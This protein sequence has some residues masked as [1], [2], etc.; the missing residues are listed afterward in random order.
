MFTL[1]WGGNDFAP[2]LLVEDSIPI[3]DYLQ[4]H[5]INSLIK[6]A[7]KL[8]GLPNVIGF[9]VMNEP[10]SGYIGVEDL[11]QKISFTY[12]GNAPTPAQSI[13]LGSGIPTEVET[14]SLGSFGI[15]QGENVLLNIAGQSAWLSG[16]KGIWHRQ[17]VWEIVDDSAIILQPNYFSQIDG[18]LVDFT[19]D[20]FK[21]FV[22]D[23]ANAIHEVDSTWLIFIEPS[24][25]PYYSPLPD[26]SSDDYHFVYAGHAYDQFTLATKRFIPWIAIS[27]EGF[28]F[29]KKNVRALF[30][31]RIAQ[32]TGTTLKHL[33]E[34]PTVLGEFGI[35]LNLSGGK[36]FQSGNFADQ[37]AALNLNLEAAENGLP[38]YTLWNY[39]ADNTNERGDQW[40]GED[41]S[42]FSLSQR[43]D[44]LE[45]NSGGRALEAVVRPYAFKVAGKII[46]HQYYSNEKTFLLRYTPDYTI[47][48]PTEIFVP[49]IHFG[50]G[51]TVHYNSGTLSFDNSRDILL[52]N[53]AEGNVTEITIVLK[54][55][56]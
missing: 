11:N 21:P 51:Y 34:R 20:Y 36:S 42:I 31:K 49:E 26:W 47:K 48:Q 56:E 41:L 24:I 37:I 1:F 18:R 13:F 28:V 23:F 52:L 38:G 22:E 16:T 27:G 43:T 5:Y 30:N 55:S 44:S 33:G 6:V 9:E 50:K 2:D 3:Q 53:T 39:T 40:N 7:V 15:N 45:I 4:Q 12:F 32:L 14:Y 46:E 10:S 25:F 8:K 29:G 19:N 35:P 54:A 17:K